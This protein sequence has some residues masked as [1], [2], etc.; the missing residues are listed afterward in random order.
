M[1]RRGIAAAL[2]LLAGAALAQGPRGLWFDPTQLPTFTGTV[3]RYLPNPRG[4]VDGLLFREGPQVVFPPPIA[5]SLRNAVAP[6]RSIVVWGIRARNAPVITML[7]W[8]PDERSE[9]TMVDRPAWRFGHDDY[10]VRETVRVEGEVRAPLLTAQGEVAGAILTDGAV[11]RV[12]PSVAARLGDRLK[13]GARLAA[14]GRG[15]QTEHGL[16][17]WVERIGDAP[18]KLEPL[19]T[20][21]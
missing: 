17:I 16:A 5:E 11:L 7:A 9:P 12:P 4:E 3:E 20:G 13:P 21:G 8:A 15:A 10:E 19:P 6:G 2:L 1:T 14:E 18:D